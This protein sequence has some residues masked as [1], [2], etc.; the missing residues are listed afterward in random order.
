MS[1]HSRSV[2]VGPR[3][4]TPEAAQDKA[5]ALDQVRMGVARAA[6]LEP[7]TPGR[8]SVVPHGLVIGGGAAGMAC[9]M[10]LARQGVPTTLIEAGDSLGGRLANPGLDRV[11]PSGRRGA[12]ILDHLRR[13]VEEA[14]VEVLLG[15][16]LASVNGAVGDFDV[17]LAGSNGRAGVKRSLKV[18]A[19]ALAV[20]ADVYDPSGRFGYG[21]LEGVLTNQD[22]AGQL[23]RGESPEAGSAVFVQCVGSRGDA[24]HL[25]CSGICCPASVRQ[26]RELRKKGVNVAVLHRGIRAAD[27]WLEEEYRQARDDGVLFARYEPERLPEILGNGRVNAVRSYDPLLR[28]EMEFP[29]DLVVLASGLVPR[30]P[31]T[32][33]LQEMLK[34]PRSPEGFLAEKHMELAPVETVVDGVM[35]CGT[36]GGGADI[37]QSVSQGLG[38]AGKMVGLLAHDQLTLDA[39][40][41]EV[42]THLC[43]GCGLCA[44]ICDFHAPTMGVGEDGMPVARIESAACKGCGTCAACCPTGA[45]RAH[46]FTDRQIFAM[47]DAALPGPGGAS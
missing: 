36:I 25:W 11:E 37:A 27:R 40:L 31:A 16:K 13:G 26:A 6:R 19:I 9:A 7:L 33:D 12:E 3:D 23:A 2:L 39:A 22:L 35:L 45:I 38:A 30:E 29:A 21:S 8:V 1:Q 43:R 46:H 4:G 42:D 28:R 34:T 18:G 32:S 44:T 15:T 24:D 5:R 41:A 14:G 47:V 20:G 17:E 10:S